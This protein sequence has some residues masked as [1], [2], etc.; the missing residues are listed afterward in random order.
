LI[1]A[2]TTQVGAPSGIRTDAKIL[3][4]TQWSCFQ[5][6]ELDLRKLG[7]SYAT[8]EWNEEL[9]S[10][11]SNVEESTP[12][13]SPFGLHSEMAFADMTCFTYTKNIKPETAY[14]YLGAIA[15][16]GMDIVIEVSDVVN[17]SFCIGFRDGNSV[18]E[19]I[20]NQISQ[21]KRVVVSFENVKS[22][23][24]AFLESAIGQLYKGEIPESKLAECITWAGVSPT[25]KLLIERAIS[26][27]KKS[28]TAS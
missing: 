10:S 5:G 15:N 9:F 11:A 1:E 25:R 17:S 19:K 4:L 13:Q 23:S 2:Q 3:G 18:F 6:L 8:T 14:I 22:L 21:G 12:I 28:K 24:A 7:D 26:E 16:M 27:A 20:R